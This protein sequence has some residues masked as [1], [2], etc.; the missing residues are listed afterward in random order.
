MTKATRDITVVVA[1]DKKTLPQLKVSNETWAKNRPELFEW[2]FL[3][4]YDRD[5]FSQS[6]LAAELRGT[7][8]SGAT[9]R[10][11]PWPPSQPSLCYAN[12]REKMLTAFVY[13]AL[14]V[15]TDWWMKIDADA[16]AIEPRTLNEW[17]PPYWFE[18]D[19][20]FLA[21]RDQQQF[22]PR[23]YGWIASPW[24]YTK[25][26]RQMADLDAWGDGVPQ[27]AGHPRL[28]L[29]YE[30]TARRCRHPRMASWLSFYRTDWSR[31][32]AQLAFNF[33]GQWNL[34]VP[35]QDGYVFYCAK[36]RGDRF[37]RTN[38]KRRGWTNVPKFSKLK[39]RAAEA[40]AAT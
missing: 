8:L 6:Q 23:Y 5:A 28:N 2:P 27:L 26:A 36:R 17:A 34:P 33:S 31:F 40:L 19:P 15:E 29:P 32:V 18:R 25:P 4:I 9:V 13:A 10:T 12:Q 38:M 37:L 24:S 39:L 35:S 11:M 14:S 20:I 1:V 30:P 16:I 3:L 21:P 7:P 22:D